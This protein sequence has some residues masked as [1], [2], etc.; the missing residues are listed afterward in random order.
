[1]NTSVWLNKYMIVTP[2]TVPNI[3]PCPPVA[4]APP[5]ITA[6]TIPNSSPTIETGLQAFT[7][8]MLSMPYS[9][10]KIPI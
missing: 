6:A 3:V 5:M 8:E 1:M 2:N 10:P 7:T 4:F 9:A